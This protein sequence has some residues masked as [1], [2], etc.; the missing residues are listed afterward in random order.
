MSSLGEV[1]GVGLTPFVKAAPEPAE[2]LGARAVRS[3][4]E[5]AGADLDDVDLV[6]AGSRFEHPALGQRVLRR[7]GATGAPVINT[8]NACVSGMTGLQIA[9]AHVGAG[10]ARLAVVVGVERPSSLGRGAIPLPDA[11]PYG[12]VGLTH[13]A[14][15]ALEASLYASTY[16]VDPAAFAG[17]A[18]KNRA[19]AVHNPRA[20]FRT[21][22]SLE[23]VLGAPMAA[24]PLTRLQ[25]CANADGA[26]AVV[27]AP[28]GTRSGAVQVR[29]LVTESGR[30]AERKPSQPLTTR[31]AARAYEQAGI[32]PAEVDVA[33]VYD[34][35]SILEVLST[36]QLGFASEGSAAERIARGEFGL[37]SAGLTT[38]PSGGLLGRGHPLGA[39][40][41]AQLAEVVDRVRGR[42]GDRQVR[43]VRVGLVHTLG[44]NLRDLEAN[45]VAIAVLTR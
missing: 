38:N 13:P 24:T 41:V 11:D 4:L 7:L 9:L 36:E 37:A 17:V 40:G 15:Y 23:E 6:V 39:T 29:A 34:G 19:H 33:E 42:S 10:M 28:S 35:F 44:G 3:A 16:G 5:D 45:A 27:V 18:V 1:L 12:R 20:R 2:V 43:P 8:E 25:C 14:K 26:V 21:P 31:A 30:L 32:G 22:V